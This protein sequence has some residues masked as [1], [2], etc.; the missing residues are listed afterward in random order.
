MG[1]YLRAKFDV[2]SI[3]L[4][5]FRQRVILAPPPTS[6]R[7]PKKPTQIRVKKRLQHWRFPVKFSELL[8]TTS[9]YRIPLMAASN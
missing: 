8:R 3:I 6:K 1:V 7:T 4:T 5:S 2:F 9:F